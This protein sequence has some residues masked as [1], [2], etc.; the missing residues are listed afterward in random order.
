LSALR[1]GEDV[2]DRPGH[3]ADIGHA[4][5]GLQLAGA[6]IVADQRRGIGVVCGQPRP[7]GFGI[8]VG[9][10][11]EIVRAAFPGADEL[12]ISKALES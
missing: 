8:V 6:G 11:L 2:P 4:I 10:A 5:D 12:T 9:A 7:H 3:F 1:L